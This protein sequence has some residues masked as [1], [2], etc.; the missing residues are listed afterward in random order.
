[1]RTDNK[2][3]SGHAVLDA[4]LDWQLAAQHYPGAVIHIEQ[5]GRVLARRTV[6]RLDP[7]SEAPMVDD[8][9]FRIASMTK[10]LVSTL[11]LMLVEQDRL[12]LDEPA[13]RWL[14]ELEALKLASGRPPQRLPTLRDLLRHTSGFAYASELRDPTLRSAALAA[15]IDGR[16][17]LLTPQAL[18]GALVALP[19]AAEPGTRFLY[20]FSTDVLG[21]IIERVTGMRLGDALRQALLD[22]LGMSDTRFGVPDGNEHRLARAYAEDRGWHGFVDAYARAQRE[23]M[24]MQS[25]GAGLVSS[26]PDYARFAR[27]LADGGQ[28]NGQRFLSQESVDE[29]FSNQLGATLAGPAGFTGPG[30]GFGLGLAVRLDWGPSAIPSRAGELTWFG[31]CGT[32]VW[33]QPRERWFA[34]MFSANMRSRMLSRMEFRRSVQPL[35]DESRR[36]GIA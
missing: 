10:P 23:G 34:L 36:G 3:P 18:L 7:A 30:F 29:M 8:A 25:G 2:K 13:S 27:L 21:L 17:P 26:V 14:P 11:A 16:L 9:L 6:G 31:I 12:A 32:V 33:M 20:S 5:A 24:P 28:A 19:L 22:P 15:D 1:M 4:F 35:L